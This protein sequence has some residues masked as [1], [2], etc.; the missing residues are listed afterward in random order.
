[1]DGVKASGAVPL[2]PFCQDTVV[3]LGPVNHCEEELGYGLEGG[4]GVGS[5]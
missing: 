2:Y 4:G 1:M 3:V 5:T